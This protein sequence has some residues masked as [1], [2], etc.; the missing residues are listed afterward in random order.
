MSLLNVWNEIIFFLS[1]AS[2]SFLLFYL[3]CVTETSILRQMFC[4]QRNNY[5][6]SK[7]QRGSEMRSWRPPL[8]VFSPTDTE[9][10]RVDFCPSD[11]KR[12]SEN[13]VRVTWEY[14]RFEDNLDKPPV[15][16]LISSNRNPGVEFPWGIYPVIYEASDR[17]GNK[18][19]CEFTVEV[20]RKF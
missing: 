4:F 8:Y 17:A 2:D 14:P 10:P 11:I 13:A 5:C 6:D 1:I 19:K 16:L 15:Q 7:S 12:E 18:A 3:F 9:R 20:G